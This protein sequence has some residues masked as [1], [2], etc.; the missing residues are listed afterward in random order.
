MGLHNG[1][2]EFFKKIVLAST[3]PIVIDADG[4]NSLA[5]QIDILKKAQAPVILTPHPGEM[6]RLSGLDASE[7]QWDRVGTAKRFAQ[8]WN[9]ILV[10]KGAHTVI[11][12]PSGEAFINLTGNS[13]MAS[14]GMG[15]ALTG[16]ITGLLSQGYEPFNAAAL[17]AYIH[18]KAGDLA[19]KEMGGIGIIATDLIRKIPA[20]QQSIREEVFGTEE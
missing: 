11:A 13:G 1:V 7:I 14:A 2:D 19:L 15:D 8:E 6:S 17:G 12:S 10:L 18:G 4:L 9:V 5:T 20:V 16:I 3:V